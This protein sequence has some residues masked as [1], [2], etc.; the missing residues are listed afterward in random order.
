VVFHESKIG[1][2]TKRRSQQVGAARFGYS[3]GLG[4]PTCGSA[5]ALG[6]EPVAY[7]AVWGVR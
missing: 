6:R 7:R 2:L 5:G 1:V 3:F 4:E